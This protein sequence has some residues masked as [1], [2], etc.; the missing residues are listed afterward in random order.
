MKKI[1]LKFAF[2]IGFGVI[3]MTLLIESCAKDKVEVKP[4]TLN[5]CP[6][7]ISFSKDI[8]PVMLS[9]C[10]TNCHSGKSL[11]GGFDLS[12]FDGVTKNVSK[13]LGSMRQ[14]GSA[15]SMPKNGSKLADSLIQ[16]MNCWI[17]QGTKNN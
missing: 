17:N 10:T 4:V 3:F 12:N 13:V 16:K 1:N 8:L 2:I 5:D 11:G 7:E 14:D 9:N 15:S 6:T